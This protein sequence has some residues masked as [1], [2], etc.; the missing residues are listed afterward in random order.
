MS[1]HITLSEDDPSASNMMELPVLP[2]ELYIKEQ[3]DNKSVQIVE[4]GEITKLRR[5][6]NPS[7]SID[8]YFPAHRG[9]YVDSANLYPPM[10]YIGW[11]Q[12]WANS[13]RPIR[14]V[15]LGGT[16]PISWPV[17]IESFTWGEEGGAVGDIYYKLTL[18]RYTYYGAR[19]VEIINDQQQVPA[20]G[21]EQRPAKETKGIEPYTVQKGDT[22]W[23]ICKRL[24]GSGS[25]YA[26][27]AKFNGIKNANLIYPGQ[28]IRFP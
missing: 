4:L 22:L 28:V 20:A 2:S 24:L 25:K 17:S 16:I 1:Y 11:L 14:L 23:A 3:P 8:S 5:M 6:K 12:K 15:V 26:E 27:I 13:K 21:A 10:F 18:K 7:I 9:P 19:R